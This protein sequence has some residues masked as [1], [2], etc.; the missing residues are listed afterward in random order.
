MPSSAARSASDVGVLEAGARRA[1]DDRHQE[2]AAQ[3]GLALDQ[4]R[5]RAQQDVGS[6]E[7]LEPPHEE[8]DDRVGGQ[9]QP[10][11]GVALRTRDEDAEVDAGVHDL[12]AGRVRGVQV[13]QLARLQVGVGDE[14]VGGLDDL[15]LAQQPGVRLRGVTLGERGVLDLRH[16]VHG[17]DQ[18]DRPAVADQRAHLAREPVVG[19]DEVEPAVLVAG[20]G[21]QQVA[22]EDAQL[23]GQ[24]LLAE[25]LVGAGGDVVD[26][27]AGRG[28]DDG[29]ERRGG[30]PGV[31]L[32]LEVA[33]GEA[34][35]QLEHVDV[36]PAGV[37]GA[38]LVERGGVKA[39]HGNPPRRR[40]RGRG[41]TGRPGRPCDPDVRGGRFITS[42]VTSAGSTRD[43]RRLFPP[44]RRTRRAHDVDR[45]ACPRPGGPARC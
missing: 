4:Q 14:H 39:D 28:F 11:A 42:Q 30:G 17:V 29:L 7:R 19:V 27:H 8:R 25:A 2:P 23:G 35:R 32:D 15:V 43:D 16:R 26:A 40:P 38:G 20:L 44:V 34:S 3:L 5:D 12:D 22:G 36:H 21:A 45:R 33:L 31:D 6:L 37:A 13:D 18:R 41:R 10:G 24:R 9:A 1:A